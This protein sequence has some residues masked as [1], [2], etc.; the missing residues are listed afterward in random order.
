MWFVFKVEWKY[1]DDLVVNDA[2]EFCLAECAVEDI[3]KIKEHI[4]ENY[5]WSTHDVK[6]GDVVV[7]MMTI[8]WLLRN[9]TDLVWEKVD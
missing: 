2:V 6:Y 9:P 5:Q 7:D 4:L 1:W 3:G 8:N